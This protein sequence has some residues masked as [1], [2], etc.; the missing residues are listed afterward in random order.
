MST[1]ALILGINKFRD[2]DAPTLAGCVND[3]RAMHAIVTGRCGARD[4][5]VRTLL[6]AQATK[7]AVVDGLDWLIRGASPGDTLV[8]FASS[9]GTS[10]PDA[11]HDEADNEDEV[12]VVHDHDWERRVLID[13]EIARAVDV[14]PQG[15][16][17]ITLWDTCHSGTLNDDGAR[18]DG[19]RAFVRNAAAP[20]GFAP[21]VEHLG[22]RF[23]PGPHHAMPRGVARAVRRSSLTGAPRKPGMADR[24]HVATLTLSA[25]DDAETAADARFQGQ[26][27]G[28][29][30]HCLLEALRE[31]PQG[32]TWNDLY[33]RAKRKVR[34]LGFDQTP[35]IHGPDSLKSA[36]AFGAAR[37]ATVSTGARPA[38]ANP[39]DIA[40]LDQ[41]IGTLEANGQWTD[42]AQVL[43][44][45]AA[46]VPQPEEK[47]R[48]LEHLVSLC[49]VKLH[50]DQ[51]AVQAAELILE[52]QPNHPG[53]TEFLRAMYAASG[54]GAKLQALQHR[55]V[56]APQGGGILASIQSALGGAAAGIG[57]AAAGVGTA[58]SGVAGAIAD[59]NRDPA[60]MRQQ[61][62]PAPSTGA[63]PA[64]PAA[65]AAAPARPT[66][67]RCAYCGGDLG[68]GAST[69]GSCG[70]SV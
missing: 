46:R 23:F 27:A 13:D 62:P 39:G 31:A 1:R 35:Q 25:C 12:L 24:P 29:F 59:A 9:H 47:I 57:A 18:A 56:S 7:A 66:A 41:R 67:R 8:F 60:W 38:Q 65:A 51:S 42:A 30:T 3:A 48:T 2:P 53:A 55:G 68:A 63:A 10:V 36:V 33:Q 54:D 14:L 61:Q 40:A 4:Q 69:C 15:A 26:A 28:A 17:L 6:D 22:G 52:V 43:L 50:D 21:G 19:T 34:D 64:R 44:Q 45:R 20:T 70:A 37:G 11:D 58:V 49:R 32:T 5:D 16:T